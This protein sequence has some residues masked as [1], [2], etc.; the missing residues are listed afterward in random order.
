[1]RSK[2]FLA[3]LVATSLFAVKGQADASTPLNPPVNPHRVFIGPDI[4]HSH[5][6]YHRKEGSTSLKLSSNGTLYGFR[7]GYEYVNP[8]HI[9][10]DLE[11][12]YAWGTNDIKE[13]YRPSWVTFNIPN[14]RKVTYRRHGHTR[15]GNIEGRMG[16]TFGKLGHFLLS[17][18]A[19]VGGYHF[20]Y[21]RHTFGAQSNWAYAALGL[22][23]VYSFGSHFDAGLNLKGMRTFYMHT[24]VDVHGDHYKRHPSNVWGYEVDLPLTWHV[25]KQWD[26]QAEPYFAKLDTS[27]NTKIWG[28]RL[29][30]GRSF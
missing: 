17:P 6:T 9:Y 22:R 11:G 1:M 23:S 28:G 7:G 16:Y 18:F 10:G 19:G 5:S 29:L 24:S 14:A 27:D 20:S 30:V 26:V 2:I 25:T 12:G 21:H 13:E 3:S 15:L 8:N 4:L